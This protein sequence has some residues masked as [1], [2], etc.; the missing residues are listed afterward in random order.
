MTKTITAGTHIGDN[1]QNHDHW[2]VPMSLS[3]MNTHAKTPKN[4]I[5]LLLDEDAIEL[6]HHFFRTISALWMLESHDSLTKLG[7]FSL[8]RLSRLNDA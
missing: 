6:F 1:T 5:P 7:V 2:I 4:P 8:E 3:A